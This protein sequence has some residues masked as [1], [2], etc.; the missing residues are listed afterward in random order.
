MSQIREAR[1]QSAFSSSQDP[2]VAEEG[3]AGVEGRDRFAD[4]AARRRER[5][6]GEPV[7]ELDQ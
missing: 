1:G 7:A 3:G 2:A 4:M 6:E 5:G